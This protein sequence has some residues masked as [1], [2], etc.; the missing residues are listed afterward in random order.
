MELDTDDTKR[1][2]PPSAKMGELQFPRTP[3]RLAEINLPDEVIDSVLGQAVTVSVYPA[4][5]AM[6]RQ[7]DPEHTEGESAYLI[8]REGLLW[9][10]SRPVRVEF[11]DD[12][13]RVW[14]C[15][16]FW[17]DGIPD[18]VVSMAESSEVCEEI[19]MPTEWDLGDIN[20]SPSVA[21]RTPGKPVRIDV[22]TVS[23]EPVEVN[24]CDPEG[25]RW[26]IPS[27][28][29]RRIVRLPDSPLLAAEG[30]P[31][32]MAD[33][34]AMQIVS[35]NYHPGSLCCMP[36]HYRFRDVYG[37]KWPVRI[38]DCELVGFGNP[39]DEG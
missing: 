15:P 36:E 23:G 34:C 19:N 18:P 22:R 16:R 29:R 21:H 2:Q 20:I 39:S 4:E 27:D 11:A 32:R 24:W 33:R 25:V 3:H 31:E 30:V 9:N 10:D 6:T 37:D 1:F 7:I 28:W 17:L 14:R 13:G 38:S 35:V 26:R 8:D 5:K 12:E